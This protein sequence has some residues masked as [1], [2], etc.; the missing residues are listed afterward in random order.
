MKQIEDD[1][2]SLVE[3]HFPQFYKDQGKPFIDF[4]EEFYQWSQQTNNYI[5]FTRNL[6]EFRDIDKTIDDFLYYYKSKYLTG[7]PSNSD[8]IKFNVK[9]SKDFY[10]SKGTERGTKLVINRIFNTSETEIYFPGKDIIKASDGEWIVPVYLELSI[11]TKT[12]TFVGKTVVGSLSGATAFVEGIGRKSVNGKY[13]DVAY[14]SKLNGNFLLGD[15]ITTDGNLS[16]CPRVIGSL[17]KITLINTGKDFAVGDIV[18]IV[19]S[20]R[21]KQGKARIDSVET[22]T[23]KVSITL[24]DGGTGYTLNTNPVFAEKMLSYTNKVSSNFFIPNFT[25]DETVF[26]PLAN[27]VFTSSNT[28]FSLGQLV[29][30]AN[31]STSVSSGRIVGK[32]QKTIRGTATS[33]TSS[34]TV[35]GSGTFFSADLANNDFIKFQSNNSTFQVQSITSNTSLELTTTGPTVTND[36]IIAANG[37]FLVIVVSGDWSLADRIQG[38]QAL[39]SSFTDRTAT[40][41]V[42][43]VNSTFIGLTSISNTFTSNDYNFIYGGYSNVYANISLVSTGSGAA[44]SIGSLTDTETVFLNTDLIGGNSSIAV[45]I[46]NGTVSCNNTSSQVNGLSTF[47]T[48]ELYPGAYIK[49]GSNNTV[50]TVNSISNNTVLNLTTNSIS[51][52]GNTIT[53][54]NGPYLT[55]PLKASKFGFPLL[56]ASNT[57]TILNLALSK[58]S[59]NLGTISSFTGFNPGSNYNISPFILVRDKVSGS[60]KRNLHLTIQDLSGTFTDGEDIVQNLTNPVFTLQTSGSST[61]FNLNETV[62]QK[63]NSTANGYGLTLSSNTL[64]S[65]IGVSSLVN[66]TFGNTFVN[67]AIGSF[68]SGTVTS[69]TSS[70]QVNGLSTLFLS[71]ISPGDF[72]KFSGNNLIFQINTVSSDTVLNL[73]TNSVSITS[74]NTISKVTNVA[75]GMTSGTLM[76]V[77]TSISSSQ[78]YVSRGKVINSSSSF[79]NVQRKTF[80]QS[81]VPNISIAGSTSGATANIISV[82]QIANSSLMGNNAVVNS[83]AGIANGS[84]TAL[85]VIDS[86]FAYEDG[87]LVSI[88]IDTN[89]NIATGQASLINQGTGEGYF[90]SNRGFLNSDKYIHDGDFYQAYSYQVRTELPLE[91]YGDTLKKL[92]HVAGTKLFGSV[93]KVSNVDVTIKSSGVQITT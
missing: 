51:A 24:L 69:N 84:V 22:S 5:Y 48:S 81:L 6:L 7:T 70:S 43:G 85:S 37:S 40:G 77:N 55:M 12:S 88:Q 26:Q 11:S 16:D 54:T 20:V 57:G 17:N 39:I 60:D 21:G 63:I 36:N 8:Q 75:V 58:S 64:L 44:L 86:G 90:K 52:A 79:V 18:N 31:S 23:G 1:I 76:F 71:E 91:T 65:V 25:V 32:V 28:N 56:L 2:S 38:S 9:H 66:S 74:T 14:L 3:D 73:T 68:L 87:E 10:S 42:M 30:G 93:V 41:K 62:T 33:T 4:V 35:T 13:F 49:I 15:I 83:T 67:S 59:F 47:F 82:T 50:F 34:N 19:S 27:I 89:N 29:T 45:S 53:I 72:I 61:G 46:L 80:N 78:V 92:V